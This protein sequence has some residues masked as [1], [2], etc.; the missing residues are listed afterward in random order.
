MIAFCLFNLTYILQVVS[1]QVHLPEGCKTISGET[2]AFV[3]FGGCDREFDP[4][5]LY[6]SKILLDKADDSPASDL[7]ESPG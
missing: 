1:V 2:A 7:T 6:L 3:I 4:H 5:F